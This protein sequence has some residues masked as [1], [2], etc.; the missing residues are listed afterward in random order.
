MTKITESAIEE[1]AIE[2][3]QQ[4]GYQHIYAPD[5]DPD[6]K[7]PERQSF[8]EVLLLNRLRQSIARINP[9]IPEDA[10]EDAIKQLLRLN[11]PELIAN[12]ETFHRM[13]TEGIT[14][15][16]RKDGSERG[17]LVWLVDFK[18]PENNEFIVAN[19]F[20]VIENNINK[21]ADV[22]LF[23]NGL[24]LVVMELKNPA[25]EN[26][27]LQSAFRQIQTY[28]QAI[29][30]LFTYNEI[31]VISDG[32]EAKAGSLS[33]DFGRFSTWKSP[34]LK[35]E[36][37]QR[38]SQLEIIIK[39][40]LNRFTLLDLVRHFIVFEK[41][42]K[43][44]KESGLTSILTIKKLAAYH[45]YYAVN[46]AVE[47]TL[48]ASGFARNAIN[49][50]L[51]LMVAEAPES[52]GLADVNSQ[53]S[54]DKKAGV[55][56]HT[57]GAG[58][59]LSMVFFAG[60]IILAMDNP[61]IVVITDRNDLD[62]QLFDT[63]A[64]SKQLLRQEPVQAQDREH[65]KKLLSVS[66]G[67]VI[68]TT[69]QKFQPDEGN[70]YPTLTDK[71][72]VIV[73]VDEAHRTQ[74]GFKAKTID[75]KD[76]QGKIT[77]KKVV[78]GFAKYLRDALPNATY[79]GFTGTPIEKEDKNTPAVFGNYVDIYDIAQ[80][81]EDGATVKI[82]YESR[83]AKIELSDEGKKLIKELD[84]ELEKED[85]SE[86]QKAKAKWTQLEALIGSK[87]RISKIAKDIVTHFE[88]RQE[89]FEGKAMI[90]TMTRQIA[91]RLYDEIIKL[92]PNWHSDDLKRGTIKVVMTSASSDGP[93]IAKH[94]TTKEQRYILSERMKN[95]EDEL[96][97]VIVCD[98]WLTGF[99]VPCLHTMYLD[100]PMKG[101]TLMQAIARV[102]RVYKDKPGGLI[103][104]Y[105]GIASDLK[106]ALSFYSDSGGKGDPAVLQEQAVE[107]MLQKLEI[108]SQMFYGFNYKKY[109]TAD[110]SAKLSIILAAEEHILGLENG[111][112]RYIDEV[113]ALSKAFS[114]AIP[115]EQAMAIKDEVAFFQAV[116]ARLVKFDSTGTG[117]TDEEIET[118]I[119][120]VIDKAL[121]TD[122][123]IDIFDAAGI[124][125]PDISVL[126][127]DF[128]LEVKNMEHKN[129]ALEVLKKL[130][131]DEIK[132]RMKKNLVQSRTLMEMLEDSIKKYHNKV[133]TAVEVIEELIQLSK[134]I[135]KMDKEAEEMGLSEYEYAFY[136]AIADNKSARELMQKEQLRELAVVIYEK[137]KQNTSIDWTIKESVRAKLRVIVKRTLK[138]Y[139]YPPDMQE[140]ATET[141]IK[142]AEM[143][144]EELTK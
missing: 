37:P 126:S 118:A 137:V 100:K 36:L 94:H 119:R 95:P 83:L 4:L 98:M 59:S 5:I 91:A 67:G 41:S 78:Y 20:T 45:Q 65:L 7:T 24:P 60:K 85:L 103:V 75:A 87:D 61:T 72:N 63:F 19:Q 88:Q 112:K 44:D 90:V 107:L 128:L 55:I 132:A 12:N 2:L 127:E 3:L 111:R 124:K 121:V 89:V 117:K 17:D 92:R 39:A 15:S 77:G 13:L 79:I 134:D 53:P 110:T 125:K 80:A 140:L 131:N 54:G 81:Q 114:I 106:E 76:E 33:A 142:Q 74:Y 49:K 11:S 52:Y 109:F 47:S 101:H 144:A 122:K 66:S 9:T 14:V 141:V 64:S 129:I 82:Y 46:R 40:M 21:R 10:R 51:P 96:K 48:R 105:L 27:T 22:I 113:T 35:K 73:I 62:D 26:A 123:V 25:D 57:Q 120:Q 68:F 30:S 32:L 108:V 93:E 115:H 8:E 18:N 34:D 29:P 135:K 143:I 102:N 130:L 38:L 50:T 139:G 58:K 6:S 99:D 31:N 28:K 116:K 84:E 133:I 104:D 16:Y 70:I 56:W 69:I 86:T 138:K 97:L 136:T 71:R 43:V 42:K 1:F 23:V